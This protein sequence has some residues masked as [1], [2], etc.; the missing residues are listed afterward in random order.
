M[1]SRALSMPAPLPAILA[2]NAQQTFNDPH[3]VSLS[4]TAQLVCRIIICS[5]HSSFA[6]D[7]VVERVSYADNAKLE[8][9]KR[10]P[11]EPGCRDRPRATQW[12][13]PDICK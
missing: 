7:N 1:S 2:Q 4:A 9:V 11:P 8:L 13:L 6:T 10:P 12:C 3:F 5:E